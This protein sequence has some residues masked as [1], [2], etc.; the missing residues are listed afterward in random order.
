MPHPYKKPFGCANSRREYGA[1]ELCVDNSLCEDAHFIVNVSGTLPSSSDPAELV[2]PQKQTYVC[3]ADGVGSWREFGVDPRLYSHKLVEN[4]QKVIESDALQ[5]EVLTG[6]GMVGGG[7]GLLTQDPIHPLDVIMDAW[8]MTAQEKVNGSCTICIAT[9]DSVLNQLSYSN[10]GDCGL[11]VLR[12]IDSST[13]G[14]MRE[15]QKPRHLRTSDLRIAYLSQ[16][17]LRSFNLPYQ[18]GYTDIPGWGSDGKEKPKEGGKFET[19]SDADTASIPL[20]P[21]DIIVLASDGLFD[22]LGTHH[23]P[24]PLIASFHSLFLL[25]YFLVLLSLSPLSSLHTHTHTTLLN[26][27]DLD[28]I[29]KEVEKWEK[30]WY[31]GATD[32]DLQGPNTNGHEAIKA[33]AT[34]LVTTARTLSLD[35]QRD[36]P[37]AVL[38]KEND[39]MWGGGMPDDT[40]VVAMRVYKA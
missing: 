23:L 20:L 34:S 8:N 30:K 25:L 18:L 6:S 10:L 12:H 38:A 3:V 31:Q 4:A 5:R 27:T 40:T 19:P 26:P 9:V 14:Y 11:M 15:R 33:L 7:L 22:N 24:P 29:V 16:Q 21:G 35:K 37:F 28:D 13:A 32:Q 17:Q 1:T 2:V 39:I 36:G